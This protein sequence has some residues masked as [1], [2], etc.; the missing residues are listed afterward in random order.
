MRKTLA[1]VAL[2]ILILQAEARHEKF[3]FAEQSDEWIHEF[4]G[5][6]LKEFEKSLRGIAKSETMVNE[7]DEIKR[8]LEIVSSEIEFYRS[9]GIESNASMAIKPFLLFSENLKNLAV[10]QDDFLKGIRELK[11]GKGNYERVAMAML[12]A[13]SSIEEM[14]RNLE[15]IDAIVF[16]NN[17]TPLYFNTSA[18]R[19]A[20]EE[21][22]ELFK[23]YEGIAKAYEVDGIWVFVSKHEAVLFENVRIW[24][25]A[26]NVTPVA[27]F[28]D[29]KR[30]EPREMDYSFETLGKHL[31]YAEGIRENESVISNL[32]EVKVVKIPTYIFL[33]ASSA[34]IGEEAEVSGLLWDYYGRRMSV[35]VKIFIDGKEIQLDARDGF[36]SVKIKRDY[37]CSVR[38]EAIYEENETHQKAYAEEILHFLRFPVWIKLESDKQRAAVGEEILF[39]GKISESLPVEIVV[40]SAKVLE[41]KADR[42]F[43]FSLNFSG[44]GKYEIFARFPGDELRRPAESNRIEILVFEPFP[45]K[46]AQNYLILIIVAALLVSA[47]ALEKFR[48][49]AKLPEEK[50]EIK[51]EMAEVKREGEIKER[52]AEGIFRELFEV[53]VKKF[54]LKKSLTPRE[55]LRELGNQRFADKLREVVELHEKFAYAGIK[56]DRDEEERFFKLSSEILS[57]L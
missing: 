19:E 16:Y 34:F 43:S 52:S 57:Q 49:R 3:A 2:L 5:E 11:E 53:L 4:F 55:L 17:T 15:E 12:K 22:E 35:P 23:L 40:N 48:K 46:A 27:L 10:A 32:V 9:K 8:A 42:N 13:K 1:V 36:F 25:Y 56:L 38:I 33:S 44:S 14:R 45:H 39:S 31:I 50:P 20:L 37:E 7:T 18:I 24:I 47:F 41:L 54:G 21:V 6:F 26:R 51:A 28:I 30:F 29:G